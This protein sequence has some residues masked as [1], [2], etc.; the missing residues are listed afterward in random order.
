MDIRRLPASQGLVWFRQAID[1]G[2][3][4]PRAVF[5]AALL[6][7]ASLYTA[8]LLMV[9]VLATLMLGGKAVGSNPDLGV[10]MAVAL[11]LT[12]AIMVLVPVLL[13]GLMHVIRETEAGRKVRARDVFAPLRNAQGRRL[14][15]LGLVQVVLAVIGGLVMMAIAGGDYW[16]DYMQAMQSVMQGAAPV[17]PEPQ[18]PGLLF[19]VQMTFNYFSYALM[20]FSI[21]LMLFSGCNV[22]TALRHALRASVINLSANLLVG[23][24]FL[25]ALMLAAFVVLLVAGLLG[26]IGNLIHAVVGSLLMMLAM[27]GFAA[28]VL[29]L[30]A[31]ASYLAWRDTFSDAASPPP[32]T[33]IHGFEA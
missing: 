15:W 22:S 18:H 32:V 2:A 19:L 5:G 27:V 10:V 24:L 3:K 31:G 23:V 13:G 25:G 14:A 11:P 9:L 33:H 29:V 28:V 1:L 6:A 8:A 7:I 20:L 16:H 12:L 17:L 21:P 30:L 4:N 26:V